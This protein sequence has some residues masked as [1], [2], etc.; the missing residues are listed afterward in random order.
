VETDA[1][2]PAGRE[3]ACGVLIIPV[4]PALAGCSFHVFLIFKLKKDIFHNQGNPEFSD[5]QYKYIHWGEAF[6]EVVFM[7]VSAKDSAML[8]GS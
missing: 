3:F 6:Q 1:C 8:C 5:F 4:G 2:L 7:P